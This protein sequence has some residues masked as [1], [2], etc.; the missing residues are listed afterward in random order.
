MADLAMFCDEKV[1]LVEEHNRAADAYSR[2]ILARRGRDTSFSSRDC[3]PST[4][5]ILS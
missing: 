2:A 4:D 5:H 3:P 1:R